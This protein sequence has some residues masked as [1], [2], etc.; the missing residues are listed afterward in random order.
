VEKETDKLTPS[1]S[2]LAGFRSFE[3]LAAQQ[4][5]GPVDDFETL[6]G[7]PS[8]DDESVGEFQAMLREWRREGS[9]TDRT[10]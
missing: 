8:P 1:Q 7:R 9:G 4:S 3:E 10:Q 2:A 6:L 5:V